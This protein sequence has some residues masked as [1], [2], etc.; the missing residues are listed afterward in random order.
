MSIHYSITDTAIQ[1]ST[2]LSEFNNNVM[3]LV[4]KTANFEQ[5]LPSN[6]W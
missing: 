5:Y 2:L 6:R 3:E 1:Q 4:K